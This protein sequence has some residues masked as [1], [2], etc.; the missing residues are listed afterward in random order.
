MSS[1]LFYAPL[2]P[3]VFAE[4]VP[5]HID[6]LASKPR[7]ATL[8]TAAYQKARVMWLLRGSMWG[9]ELESPLPHNNCHRRAARQETDLLTSAADTCTKTLLDYLSR[10]VYGCYC[11][12]YA[13]V[14]SCI[15]AYMLTELTLPRRR[16][17]HWL[18]NLPIFPEK[19]RRACRYTRQQSRQRTSRSRESHSGVL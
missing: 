10:N 5:P 3:L 16:V 19:R 6:S 2:D 8:P 1:W 9:N 13:V 15:A 17:W 18:R 4:Y 14:D 11:N 7:I 12:R